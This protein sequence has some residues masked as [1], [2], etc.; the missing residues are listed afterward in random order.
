MFHQGPRRGNDGTGCVG[1]FNT[2]HM[3]YP[4]WLPAW[5]PASLP[6]FLSCSLPGN[7]PTR[8]NPAASHA[9]MLTHMRVHAHTR[10]VSPATPAHATHHPRPAPPRPQVHSDLK[11]RS[12]VL[13]SDLRAGSAVRLDKSGKSLLTLLRHLGRLQ[14]V[15]VH[16]DGA[17]HLVYV[18][19]PE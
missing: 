7:P 10:H 17:T 15:R 5:L 11:G 3:H 14:E 18:L 2:Q 9:C 16:A 6:A 4:V 1:P 13:E 8:L 12:W 19:L